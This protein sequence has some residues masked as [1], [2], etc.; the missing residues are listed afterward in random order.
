MEPIVSF[1]GDF[2]WLSNFWPA[3]IVDVFDIEYG[4]VENAYQ[5][6]KFSNIIIREEMAHITPGAAKRLSRK[7]ESEI[8]TDFHDNKIAIM[9]NFSWQKYKNPE[10]RQLLLD[11]DDRPLIEGNTWN[12]TFWGV[13]NGVGKNNLGKILMTIRSEL[14]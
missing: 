7:L 2:R 9:R 4:S 3:K 13:C 6:S 1:S 14:K 12:D 8:Q 11:T 10:L 5:A